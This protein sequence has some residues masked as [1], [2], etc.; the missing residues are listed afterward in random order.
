[1]S[2]SSKAFLH[3][4]ERRVESA[5]MEESGYVEEEGK[6]TGHMFVPSYHRHVESEGT[7]GRVG[8]GRS[9]G[10]DVEA[11]VED[12]TS[13]VEELTA[14]RVRYRQTV[15]AGMA[16]CVELVLCCLIH[17]AGDALTHGPIRSLP[18]AVSA[19]HL[20]ERDPLD[21]QH[22]AGE[23]VGLDILELVEAPDQKEEG[24]GGDEAHDAGSHE[25]Q[26]VPS[27]GGRH[28]W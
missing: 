3:D 5:R 9:A 16:T 4:A 10:P 18:L 15:K 14:T 26:L 8:R 23:Q 7:A 27:S 17:A 25:A 13:E 2:A 11:F 21:D 12:A 19:D 28:G 1:M 24:G 22:S 6:E 20:G